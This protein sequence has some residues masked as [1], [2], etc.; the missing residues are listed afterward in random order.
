MENPLCYQTGNSK[1]ASSCGVGMGT[2]RL[3]AGGEENKF[4][5]RALTA[6]NG[7]F[8]WLR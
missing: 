6:S 8:V 2:S 1:V 5:A 7:G 4:V 3:L